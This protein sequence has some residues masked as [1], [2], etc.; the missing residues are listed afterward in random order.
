MARFAKLGSDELR[1]FGCRSD[2]FCHNAMTNSI[3]NGIE[4]VR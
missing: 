1:R 4:I 2:Q 3:E